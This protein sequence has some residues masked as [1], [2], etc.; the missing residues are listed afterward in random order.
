V[1]PAIAVA[2]R[3]YKPTPAAKPRTVARSC[4]SGGVTH[5][6][7][8]PI[9][10]ELTNPYAHKSLSHELCSGPPDLCT[11]ASAFSASPYFE[12]FRQELAYWR[13]SWKRFRQ[14]LARR[15]DV[16]TAYLFLGFVPENQDLY[17][18]L[19]KGG[20]VLVFKEVTYR[21]DG[22]PKGNVDAELVLQAMIDY[23]KYDQAVIVT[24]DGDFACLVRHLRQHHKLRIVL[25]PK[26]QH[27][28]ALLK[29]AAQGYIRYLDQ[30]RAH[31]EHK[32]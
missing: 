11:Q 8:M 17:R 16:T 30:V 9:P 19:Q 25:S 4:P 31:I 10:T 22:K 28:S 3:F 2:G 20:Y 26:R 7:K 21:E 18:S 23:P 15:Y 14:Y 12:R 27:C 29:K 6:R 32:T 24:S 13:L 5:H 1:V